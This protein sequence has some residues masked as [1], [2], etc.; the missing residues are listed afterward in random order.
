MQFV[1]L[2]ASKICHFYDSQYHMV[3]LLFFS[4]NVIAFC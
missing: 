4:V 3:S 2:R 1:K